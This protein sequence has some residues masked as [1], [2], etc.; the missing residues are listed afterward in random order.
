MEE[1]ILNLKK[2]LGL[3][4][5]LIVSFV[6]V[7]CIHWEQE[8]ITGTFESD[9]QNAIKNN[10]IIAIY[11]TKS[12]IEYEMISIERMQISFPWKYL[13]YTPRYYSDGFFINP[14]CVPKCTKYII[15]GKDTLIINN[16]IISLVKLPDTLKVFSENDS[17]ISYYFLDKKY[18]ENIDNI[19]TISLLEKI[20]S[21]PFLNDHFN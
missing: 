5:F 14:N 10:S 6:V 15:A 17:K 19:A 18:Q 12:R 4:L 11:M 21:G 13:F 20:D 8:G 3:A 7:N 9:K 2:I 1:F 16:C